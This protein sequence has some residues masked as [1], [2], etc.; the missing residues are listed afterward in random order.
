MKSIENIVFALHDFE[1]SNPED[2][3]L[4]RGEQILVLKKDEGFNDGWWEGQNMQG[5]KG[6]FPVIYTMTYSELLKVLS[7]DPLSLKNNNENSKDNGIIENTISNIDDLL[8]YIDNN[9][10]KN[11]TLEDQNLNVLNWSPQEVAAWIESK[12]FGSFANKFITHEITGDILVQMNYMH[13]KEL[14][15]LSFGKRFEIEREIKLLRNSLPINVEKENTKTFSQSSS[16]QD[17][18]SSKNSIYE[19]S[20]HA[21]SIR[22]V[23]QVSINRK[24]CGSNVLHKRNMSFDQVRR[25]STNEIS[26]DRLSMTASSIS[27]DHSIFTLNENTIELSNNSESTSLKLCPKDLEMNVNTK[28]KWKATNKLVSAYK[29]KNKPYVMVDRLQNNNKIFDHKKNVRL[30]RHI[31]QDTLKACPYGS[32]KQMDT[33][34]ALKEIHSLNTESSKTFK[35]EKE[36]S[37]IPLKNSNN[38]FKLEKEP[39]KTPLKKPSKISITK[40]SLLKRDQKLLTGIKEGIRNISVQDAIKEADYYG[41]M[42]K[43]TERYGQ[44]KHLFFCLTGTRLSY[45]YSEDGLIDINSYRVVS[46]NNRFFYRDGKF[47]FKIVPPAPGTARG[48]TFTSPK[49]HY[50]STDSLEDMKGWVRA[51]IKITIGRDDSVPVLSSCKIPTISLKAAREKLNTNLSSDDN[52]KL[53]HLN[54]SVSEAV[55]FQEQIV[56]PVK[57]YTNEKNVLGEINCTEDSSIINDIKSAWENVEILDGNNDD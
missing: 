32:Y 9:Y 36:S 35:L 21:Q 18:N 24:S 15:I 43:K 46:M 3:P 41:W 50:F 37:K 14:G 27:L 26:I 47:C 44:W 38:S 31:N 12:G 22:N 54:K 25:N 29:K 16:S 56:S 1:A 4:K 34:T 30:P 57:S 20:E 17:M 2:L 51:F 13:L 11:M 10:F 23:D 40:K 5:Q 45:F 42:R 48:I 53:E 39:L 7:S 8:S 52:M 49:I 19:K 55:Y 28:N 33:L 6:L